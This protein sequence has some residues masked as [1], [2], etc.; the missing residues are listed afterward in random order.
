MKKH[1]NFYNIKKQ[2]VSE[3]SAGRK[4]LSNSLPGNYVL[5]YLSRGHKQIS[6]TVGYVKT[7]DS[8]HMT[9]QGHVK[10]QANLGHWHFSIWVQNYWYARRHST[11]L[12]EDKCMY[13]GSVNVSMRTLLTVTFQ[14][15]WQ[16]GDL[17][18]IKKELNNLLSCMLAYLVE[19]N[20]YGAEKKLNNTKQSSLQ[21]ENCE[22]WWFPGEKIISVW[23]VGEM[24]I[25]RWK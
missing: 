25:M 6:S 11:S 10:T 7:W 24:E 16:Q 17:T 3:Y 22:H 5:L 23:W 4:I 14:F 8:L 12:Q 1:S 2:C 15:I 18:V 19:K 13:H 20:C 9:V 21:S